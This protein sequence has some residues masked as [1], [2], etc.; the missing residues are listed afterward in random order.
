MACPLGVSDTEEGTR[1]GAPSTSGAASAPV[2]PLAAALPP[3]R[4]RA[5][6]CAWDAEG[7]L[8]MP[9]TSGLGSCAE[10]SC[11]KVGWEGP[12]GSARGQ[13]GRPEAAYAGE[14]GPCAS[15]GGGVP[16]QAFIAAFASHSASDSSSCA[17]SMRCCASCMERSIWIMPAS[18]APMLGSEARLALSSMD[19]LW[20]SCQLPG[21]ERGPAELNTPELCSCAAMA[22]AP[23]CTRSC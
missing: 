20:W 12:R 11:T 2:D 22:A 3:C 14:C 8:A 9:A 21:R 23:P 16:F 1:L 19:E 15:A 13:G 4:A 6:S 17:A 18:P 10:R 7:T 5:C